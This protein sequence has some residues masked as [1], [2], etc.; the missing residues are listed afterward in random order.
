MVSFENRSPSL[1][2]DTRLAGASDKEKTQSSRRA[3][4]ELP[5]MS[6]PSIL[7][8]CANSSTFRASDLATDT[9]LRMSA[10]QE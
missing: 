7:S 8:N 4:R 2:P 5:A 3:L 9:R 10:T 1:S 6:T